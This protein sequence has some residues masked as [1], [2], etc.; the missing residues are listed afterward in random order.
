MAQGL[1]EAVA[2]VRTAGRRCVVAT[3]R[4]LKPQEERL[5]AFFL[6]LRPDAM[7]VRSAGLLHQ[8]ARM[9]GPG[10][11]SNASALVRDGRLL[12]SVTLP[13]FKRSVVTL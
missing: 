9:G 13:F 12:K 6:R 1:W 8:L 4:V 10:G 3:P 11:V 5:V 7:L 2:H